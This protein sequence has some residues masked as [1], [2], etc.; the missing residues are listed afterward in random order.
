MCRQAQ[1]RLQSASTRGDN[2][3]TLAV[4][5]GEWKLLLGK[6]P[7]QIELFRFPQDRLEKNDLK[8]GQ[9]GEVERLKTLISDWEAMLPTE[10]N[11]KCLSTERRK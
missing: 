8:N 7:Q 6:L 9:P 10:P 4:R 11:K 3:P 1:H 5:E 2:W